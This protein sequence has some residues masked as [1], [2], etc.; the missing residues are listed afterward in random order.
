MVDS[1][2]RK[3]PSKKRGSYENYSSKD[4]FLMG[5]NAS[6][7]G[8]ASKIRKWKKAY[9]NL[10][11]STV[12]GFKQ[13]YETQISEAIW[14][15]KSPKKVIVNKLRGRPCLLGNKIEPL[16]QKYLKAT[17]CKGGV[18]NTLVAVTTA[19]KTILKQEDPGLKAFSDVQV[20]FAV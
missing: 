3:K 1:A 5:K 6:I 10:N 20:L 9:P 17:R 4:R 18:V 2:A 19:R 16:V 8:I 13:R 14:K 15:N 12:R 11:E 7:Y